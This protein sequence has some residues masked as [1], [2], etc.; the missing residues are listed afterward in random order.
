MREFLYRVYIGFLKLNLAARRFAFRL[1]LNTRKTHLRRADLSFLD[2]SGTNLSGANLREA[3]LIRAD[4]T[5]ANL[6]NADLSGADL[7]GARLGGADLTGARLTAA[8]RCGGVPPPRDG[9]CPGGE[10]LSD[11]PQERAWRRRRAT[12]SGGARPSRPSA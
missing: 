6:T 5:G 8:R 9:R 10:P 12:S 2:L 7:S 11:A 4:L 1:Y 3:S